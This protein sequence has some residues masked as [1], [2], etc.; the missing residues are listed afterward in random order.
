MEYIIPIVCMFKNRI[1]KYPVRA[2]CRAYCRYV[3][4]LFVCCHLRCSWEGNL[5]LKNLFFSIAA[6]GILI[7]ILLFMC[8]CL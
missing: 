5:V 2:E 4:G 6:V 1:D 7:I 3:N 8:K